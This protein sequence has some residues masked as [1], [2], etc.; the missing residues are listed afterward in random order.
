MIRVYLGLGVLALVL[1]SLWFGLV[2]YGNAR[3]AEDK[4]EVAVEAVSRVTT[5]VQDAGKVNASQSAERASE[6]LRVRSVVISYREKTEEALSE[7]GPDA[8]RRDA[9]R[10]RMYLDAARCINAGDCTGKLLPAVP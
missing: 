1:G 6:A 8:D 3:V 7:T 4:A 5:A 9:V 2:Q 10:L